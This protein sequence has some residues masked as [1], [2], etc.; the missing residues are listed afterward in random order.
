MIILPGRAR[1]PG[2]CSRYKN[3]P[4]LYQELRKLRKEKI[5]ME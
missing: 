4:N 2:Q 3:L 1:G 5:K